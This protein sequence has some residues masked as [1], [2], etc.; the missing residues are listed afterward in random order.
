MWLKTMEYSSSTH[1]LFFPGTVWK[2][3]PWRCSLLPYICIHIRVYVYIH[4]HMYIYIH[5]LYIIYMYIYIFLYIYVY[6]QTVPLRA[7]S[8][9]FYTIFT[10][11]RMIPQA[12][13]DHVWSNL[14][15]LVLLPL[16]CSRRGSAQSRRSNSDAGKMDQTW[17]S[18]T[19]NHP[20]L[21][22]YEKTYDF[23]ELDIC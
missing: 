16:D 14:S 13:L 21:A 19:P 18:H 5:I 23:A 4:V 3:S 22:T 1:F 10:K 6:G 17:S 7:F 11:I 12:H 8:S 9:R 15:A 20:Y 2:T